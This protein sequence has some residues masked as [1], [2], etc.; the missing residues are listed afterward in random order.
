MADEQVIVTRF[1]ADL[2]DY[3]QGVQ[4]Y[5]QSMTDVQNANKAA[6]TSA[7]NLSATTGDLGS[8][9]K[10]TAA[11]AQRAAEASAEVGR[12]TQQ[13]GSVIKRAA[14]TVKQ[15]A[16]G[17]RDGFR[18][19]I[20]EVGGLRGIVSQVGANIKGFGAS[21]SGAF[22]ALGAQVTNVAGQVPLIGGLATA[23]GPVGI[24]AAAVA[25]GFLKIFSNIDA[26]ATALDGLGKTGGLV[27]DRITGLA[28]KF[29]DAFTSSDTV[30]GRVAGALGDVL[31]VLLDI[32]T[33]PLQLL[34]E[35]TGISDALREDFAAGQRLAE[36]YD[37]LQDKQLGVNEATAKNEIE[38]RKNLAA[39]RDTTKSTQERL[40]IADAI[41][42]KEEENLKIR[43]DQLLATL[44]LKKEEAAL[45]A[46][47]DRGKGEVDDALKAEISAIN[48]QISNLEAESVSLTERVAA[49]RA[50]IVEAEEQ[51]KAKAREKALAD[52]AK[53]EAEALKLA[54]QRAE[55]ERSLDEVLDGIAA[56]RLARQQTE[57]EREVQAVK[58]KYA[59]L[60]Q[61][62]LEGIAKLRE[63]SPPNA[64]SEITRRE[65]DAI[66]AI[67]KARNE[68]LA[69]LE[70]ERVKQVEETRA[71]ALEKIR[72]SLLT[73]TQREREAVTAKYDELLS[74]AEQNIKDEDE[75]E[76]TRLELAAAREQELT[77]I[78]SEEE[79]KRT[80][81]QQAEA[82]RRQELVRQNAQLLTDF[83][84]QATGIIAA[85]AA[86]SE[87]LTEQAS[88]Q[89]VGLLLDTLEKII[90]ASAFG[91][92]A[93]SA[94]SLTPDNIATGGISG[95]A[96]GVV[97]AGLVRAL[98]GIA[99]AQLT[100]NFDGDPYVGGDGSRP[101]WSG[102]DGYI[103]RLDKGERVVT[104][105]D[106]DRYW[107]DLEA[108]RKGRWD[109]HILDKYIGPAVA[110]L[111]WEDDRKASD[112]VASDFGSRM[113]SS[114]MLAKYYDANIVR[115]LKDNARIE[116]QQTELLA[117]IARNIKPASRRY[118]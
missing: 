114:V 104:S 57:D 67:D 90:I 13:T 81:A 73:S 82:E 45:Q 59:K 93:L 84:V 116:R 46:S 79:R 2:S 65:A 61:A 105:K 51:R 109:D 87:G 30:I 106:N 91:V 95:I 112:F 1:I 69:A 113:A 86:S 11:E 35:F 31:G 23:L 83:A 107:D 37:E 27:F 99:K 98:F 9:Y 102:R 40:A 3:E 89:V 92:Q 103:R 108:M 66:I 111:Q 117:T 71:E 76:R 38:I 74:L 88:K 115:G 22:K 20:K 49:R 12:Q 34:G 72:S 7:K 36:Q 17:A 44:A 4:A 94:Q 33:G 42:K 80:E 26:G 118:Y 52:Q 15:F 63:A 96:R 24:A 43:R 29:F 47:Q 58:D 101:M 50:G 32:V 100:A 21:A 53:R 6:D 18:T 70:A 10:L 28:V 41:T 62:T 97:L 25:G 5:E 16:L 77:D 64:Q 110:A 19:A 75:L 8:K 54:E 56:D 68:E 78:V 85:A 60:E 14:D 55:A 48:T 39:L